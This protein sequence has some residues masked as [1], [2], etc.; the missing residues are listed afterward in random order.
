M[1]EGWAAKPGPGALIADRSASPPRTTGRDAISEAVGRLAVCPTL[2]GRKW[3]AGASPPLRRLQPEPTEQGCKDHS[4][5]A[6]CRK[7][8]GVQ[9]I[10]GRAGLG[11]HL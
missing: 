1:R 4:T 7:F 11:N 2:S 5:R 10:A 6:I 3:D 9:H 8:R